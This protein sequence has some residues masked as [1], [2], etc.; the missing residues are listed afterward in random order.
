MFGLQGR[1]ARPALPGEQE[2]GIIPRGTTATP[3]RQSPGGRFTATSSVFGS[4]IAGSYRRQAF[5]PGGAG[6]RERGTQGSPGL[7]EADDESFE[8]AGGEG[9]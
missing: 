2:E 1:T 5:D 9:G 4:M 7:M 3:R 8:D 6:G